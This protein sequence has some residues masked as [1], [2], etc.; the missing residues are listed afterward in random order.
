[1]LKRKPIDTY[2]RRATAGLPRLERVDTAAEIRVHLLQKTRELMAQGFPREEAEHLAVHE[3]GPV[4]ATNR[5]LI[6]H[7]FTSSLGW[8][9]VGVMLAGAGVWT[10]LERDWIFWKDTT[11]RS[12]QLDG[13]DLQFALRNFENFES[14]PEFK[15]FEFVLPRGTRTLEYAMISRFAH[16]SDVVFSLDEIEKRCAEQ[17]TTQAYCAQEARRFERIPFKVSLVI[18]GG[19]L[20]KAKLSPLFSEKYQTQALVHQIAITPTVTGELS[21]G[22]YTPRAWSSYM[23]TPNFDIGAYGPTWASPPLGLNEWTGFWG[24]TLSKRSLKTVILHGTS[25]RTPKEPD[26]LT[27]INQVVIAVRASNKSIKE[28]EP[29]A[30][31][32]PVNASLA[33]IETDVKK[34]KMSCPKPDETPWTCSS[35]DFNS[36]YEV[37]GGLGW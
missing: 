27:P 26:D 34:S 29:Q 9:V 12:V 5:A 16:R 25:L 28:L 8:I 7:I 23:E 4:A 22:Y 19:Q 21:T 33:I 32:V 11:I 13:D 6:G 2:I 3:M 37:H 36:R 18:G 14:T 10:Y 30:L 24:K 15:K 31:R 20:K 1:M 17:A 35:Y